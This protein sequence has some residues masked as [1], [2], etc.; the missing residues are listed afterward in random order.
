MNEVGTFVNLRPTYWQERRRYNEG[1][2]SDAHPEV[3]FRQIL[4]I[5]GGGVVDR[6]GG[7]QCTENVT[8][9][10]RN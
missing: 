4:R 8:K 7:F 2:I 1:D 5:F 10:H 6:V 9:K 3:S